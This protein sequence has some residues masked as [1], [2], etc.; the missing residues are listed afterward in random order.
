MEARMKLG[1]RIL[2]IVV[3]VLLAGW[4]MQPGRY[5]FYQGF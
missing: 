1:V 4:C 2:W 5:F 3:R